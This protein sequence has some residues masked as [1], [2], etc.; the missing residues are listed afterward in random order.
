[1]TAHELVADGIDGV[2]DGEVTGLLAHLREEHRF[3][4]KVAKLLA[5][6]CRRPA[7]NGFEDLVGLLEDEWAQ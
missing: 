5:K 1:M 3:K 4:E 7:L 2:A 6:L